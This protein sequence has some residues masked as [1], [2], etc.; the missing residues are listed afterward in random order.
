[1]AC[2]LRGS[3]KYAFTRTDLYDAN[4]VL[5]LLVHWDDPVYRRVRGASAI[6]RFIFPPFCGQWRADHG[7]DDSVTVSKAIATRYRTHSSTE[8]VQLNSFPARRCTI[9]DIALRVGVAVSTVSYASCNRRSI[10]LET[11]QRIQANGAKLG[12][13]PDPQISPLMAHIGRGRAVNAS[14][15]IAFV[16]M[17]ALDEKGGRSFPSWLRRHEPDDVL[18]LRRNM[19]DEIGGL[20]A[21][22][23]L[24]SSRPSTMRADP[25]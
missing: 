6:Y 1:M 14:R 2:P 20:K 7:A 15:R 23:Y 22:P 11:C 24:R 17:H 8:V 16:W 9:G 10:P 21:K 19:W 5:S 13:R 12:Y 18:L 25:R 4:V 3:L